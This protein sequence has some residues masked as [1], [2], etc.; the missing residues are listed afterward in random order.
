[1]QIFKKVNHKNTEQNYILWLSDDKTKMILLS[2]SSPL[3][4]LY[5]YFYS[6]N[7]TEEIST[8]TILNKI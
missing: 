7:N 3:C 2:C 6:K 8:D 5:T 1:M 4:S